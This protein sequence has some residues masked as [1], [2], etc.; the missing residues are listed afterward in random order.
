MKKI[1][2]LKTLI[3]LIIAPLTLSMEK[4]K[5]S[6]LVVPEEIKGEYEKEIRKFNKYKLNDDLFFSAF[7]HKELPVKTKEEYLQKLFMIAGMLMSQDRLMHLLHVSNFAQTQFEKL[8]KLIVKEAENANEDETIFFE[9][10]NWLMTNYNLILATRNYYLKQ[11]IDNAQGLVTLFFNPKMYNALP[12]LA[13]QN[14]IYITRYIDSAKKREEAS[15]RFEKRHGLIAMSSTPSFHTE[16]NE[17]S[18]KIDLLYQLLRVNYA[19]LYKKI[20]HEINLTLKDMKAKPS[21]DIEALPPAFEDFSDPSL[22]VKHFPFDEF[23]KIIKEAKEKSLKKIQ[24]QVVEQPLKL[25]EKETPKIEIKKQSPLDNSYILN[26]DEDQNRV[27]IH[28]TKNNTVEVILKNTNQV[29]IQKIPSLNYTNNVIEWL[30][31]PQL[32]LKNQG[33]STP[34]HK[35]YTSEHLQQKMLERHSFS[36]LIDDYINEIGIQ[37]VTPN[38]KREGQ[39]D[40]LI[41]IPGKIIYS[42]GSEES[43]YFSYIIDS[44]TR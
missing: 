44:K 39:K 7:L 5:E 36:R 1:L 16:F 22:S 31:N 21:Q 11:T 20:I 24:E 17:E 26:G 37:T 10:T 43:G 35:N 3:L 29:R 27:I 33:Y 41:S 40:I 4:P 38:R 14:S 23:A 13:K 42:N 2:K 6:Q 15:A 28:N 9:I 19:T 34:G 32:A 18:Q 30:N 12:P 8:K 25:I